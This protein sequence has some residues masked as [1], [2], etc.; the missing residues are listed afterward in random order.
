M[1]P[2]ASEEIGY[3]TEDWPP[4]HEE[5]DIAVALKPGAAAE[6][7]IYRSLGGRGIGD[8]EL[9]RLV[10]VVPVVGAPPHRYWAAHGPAGLA[11]AGRDGPRLAVAAKPLRAKSEPAAS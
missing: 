6:F 9:A 5:I 2:R 3:I 1:A 10:V 7:S 8:R 11:A 4:D